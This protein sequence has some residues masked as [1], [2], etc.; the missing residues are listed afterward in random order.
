LR[1]FGPGFLS[2]FG[3][4][5]EGV[6]QVS[7]MKTES[8]AAFGNVDHDFTDQ[9]RVSLGLRYT[10]ESKDVDYA[11][12]LT[13][14]D[15][16]LPSD[17]IDRHE[18]EP[19]ALFQTIDF[20][21]KKSWDDVSG[22]LSFD[23]R[24]TPDVLGYVSYARGFNSGNYNGG[25]F[26]DQGEATLVDPETLNSYEVGVKSELAGD[27]V[28]LNA[29]V[30]YYDFKDQQVFILASGAGGAPFQQL[31]NA[32]A[33]TIYG[34][35][36]DFAWKPSENWL[37][38]GGAGY[39]HSKF[40]EFN[41]QLGGDLS[42]N[43]LPSAPEWNFNVL[44]QYEWQLSAGV[45]SVS[46]DTKY[47]DDQFFSVNNDPLLAQ[48]AYWMTNA[49]VSFEA[50]SHHWNVTVWGRNLA[51]QKYLV[52]GFDLAAFGFD[53]LV[54]GAPRTYGVTLGYRL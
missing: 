51:D 43:E 36:V 40:D 20:H 52:A 31:S 14:T 33:S 37:L 22:R 2:G 13:D 23:Y 19:I 6:G 34:A 11:A 53:Q 45:L 27:T 18:I 47:Q 49:R 10:H 21:E 12:Y 30:Y 8:Y 15:N 16:V 17:F 44:A 25:A 38:Q 48:D 29:D 42:G 41:S 7:E 3:T 39:T 24:F 35:E 28:R 9:L 5:L 46:A 54:V 4:T 32:A 50:A 26:F 1:G